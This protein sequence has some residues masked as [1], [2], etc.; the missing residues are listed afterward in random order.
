MTKIGEGGIHPQQPSQMEC[1][2]KLQENIMRFQNAL[3]SYQIARSP[4][5]LS[6][7][8]AIM[9]QQM[10]MI[11]SAINEVK[12]MGINKQGEIV[13]KDYER[14]VNTTTQLNLTILQ[15][16]LSTLQEYTYCEP[17]PNP[18]NPIR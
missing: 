7:L 16:D 9:N 17:V 6:H 5:E 11:Q 18:E 10:G 3:A 1:S 14:Y 4:E 8:E 2:K 15:Q 12:R 13:R